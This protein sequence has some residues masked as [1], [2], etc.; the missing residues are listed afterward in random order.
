MG[1]VMAALLCFPQ[2]LVAI[3]PWPAGCPLCESHT[4]TGRGATVTPRVAPWKGPMFAHPY[5]FGPI[6]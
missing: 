6:E 3:L 2:L 1:L 5:Y 4:V